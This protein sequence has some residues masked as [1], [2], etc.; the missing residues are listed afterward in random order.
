MWTWAWGKGAMVRFFF[1]GMS[2]SV[3]VNC[4]VYQRDVIRLTPAVRLCLADLI[5]RF[6]LICVCCGVCL[7]KFVLALL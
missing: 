1:C 7:E 4:E 6:W 2:A 5:V 3:V